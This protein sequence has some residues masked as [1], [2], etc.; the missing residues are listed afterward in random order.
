MTAPESKIPI[1]QTRSFW[2]GQGLLLKAGY[3]FTN[4]SMLTCTMSFFSTVAWNSY[5]SRPWSPT[6]ISLQIFWRVSYAVRDLGPSGF[7][8]GVNLDHMSRPHSHPRC[9]QHARPIPR[10][11]PAETVSRFVRALCEGHTLYLLFSFRQ[12]AQHHELPLRSRQVRKFPLFDVWNTFYSSSTLM[13][14]YFV[15]TAPVRGVQT[16]NCLAMRSEWTTA[17]IYR[18][19]T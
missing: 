9:C 12:I 3:H 18:F 15:F 8:G 17:N 10:S 14:V 11:P 16:W 2:C 19:E 6:C 4:S 1:Y 7:S 13:R 5:F